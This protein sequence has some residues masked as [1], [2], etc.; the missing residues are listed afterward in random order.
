[1]PT[2]LSGM[3]GFITKEV[4][5]PEFWLAESSGLLVMSS[6]LISPMVCLTL[7]VE[8]LVLRGASLKGFFGEAMM[9]A[10]TMTRCSSLRLILGRQFPLNL[11]TMF[12]PF[13]TL[14]QGFVKSGPKQ[15]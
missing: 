8:M 14:I 11:C 12:V 15:F 9:V 6:G 1:M 5:I 3:S 4:Y 7:G 10:T 2:G 13:G